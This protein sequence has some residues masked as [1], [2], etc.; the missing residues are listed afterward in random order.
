VTKAKAEV[1]QL[2]NALAEAQLAQHVAEQ[3]AVEA[4]RLLARAALNA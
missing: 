4:E 3:E 2:N 1:A